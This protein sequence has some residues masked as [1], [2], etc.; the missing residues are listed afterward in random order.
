MLCRSLVGLTMQSNDPRQDK[1]GK[2][3]FVVDCNRLLSFVV[4]FI[5]EI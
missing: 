4:G 2:Q 3:T 1:V 5:A